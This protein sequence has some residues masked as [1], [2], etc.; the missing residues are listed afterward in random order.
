MS[1]TLR[2][3]ALVLFLSVS[4]H[5]QT[6]T[7]ALYAGPAPGLPLEA[8]SAMRLEL[9][10]LV[11]PAGLDIVWKATTGRTAGE[12]FELL[13]VASFEGPCWTA[14]TT[15]IP[16]SLSLADTSVTDGRILP[17]FHVD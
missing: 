15:P 7:L 4:G 3:M 11:S 2:A 8:A 14:V 13:A 5:A 9:Q 10:R 12:N 1:L 6:R 16:V 17:F